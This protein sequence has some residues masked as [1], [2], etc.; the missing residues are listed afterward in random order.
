MCYVHLNPV[1]PRDKNE[2]VPVERRA[3]LGKWRWSSHLAY[4]G[5]VPAPLGSAPIGWPSSAERGKRPGETT[6]S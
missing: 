6:K 1:R 5:R 2:I 3:A 4:L